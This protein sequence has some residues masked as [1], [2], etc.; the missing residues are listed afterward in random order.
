M[1]KVLCL[2]CAVC[3]ALTGLSAQANQEY[4]ARDI[5]DVVTWGAGGGTD[6]VN[7][8]V[9]SEM[10]KDLDTHINVSNVTGGVSASTGMY[11]AYE[12]GN[13]GYTLAGVSES[14]VAAAVMGGFDKGMKVWDFFIVGGSPDVLSVTPNAP[15]KTLQELVEAAKADPKS[16]KVGAG[17]A[18]S[19][20]HLNCVAFQNGTG[21]ELNFIPYDGSAGS[22]NAAMTGEITVCI[23]SAQ[24]QADLIKAGKLRPLAMLTPDTFVIGNVTI[25]SAFTDY[26]DLSKYLPI[27]QQIGFAVRADVDPAIKT[28]LQVAFKKAMQSQAV[29]DFGKQRYFKMTGLCGDEANKT[30]QKLE[31]LF[32][33]TLYDL[34]AAKISPEKFGITR[35]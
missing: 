7:R 23:T 21:V 29:T 13:D 25:P 28:K 1:K 14:N 16:I 15:Y 35:L 27:S 10:E 11:N 12:K 5:S 32:S 4:P 2:F 22:Q 3:V 24:E 26:P 30:M 17:G 31:S 9:M 34:G 33:W 18:G 6:L 8:L 20:H 19:I